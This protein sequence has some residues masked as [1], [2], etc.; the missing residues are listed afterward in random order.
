VEY[1]YKSTVN[2][3]TKQD[4]NQSTIILGHIGG[5]MDDPEYPVL[6]VM[7]TILGSGFTSRLFREV[8]SRQGLAYSVRGRYGCGFHHPGLFMVACQTQSGKTVHAI[9]AM[10]REVERITESMVT[11]EELATAKEAFLNAFVL[12]YESIGQIAQRLLA[13]EY[14][15]YPPDFLERLRDGVE[16][17][18]RGQV[19]KVARQYLRPQAM[20]ILVVGRPEDFD[21]D[22]AVLGPVNH[23]DVTIPEPS[24]Q[25]GR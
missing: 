16:Q 22:L 12:N 3:I 8:R 14:Y 4:I 25:A 6:T 1:Q 9:R 24:E 18:T 10:Q 20:Q 11:Q 5:R 21:Q 15:G 13:Y 23:I 2:L 7:E 17:V 19:L